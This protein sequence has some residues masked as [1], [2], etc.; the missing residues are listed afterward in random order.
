M[1]RILF[2]NEVTDEERSPRAFT[3]NEALSYFHN[4]CLELL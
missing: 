1:Y 2:R 4:M 3:S